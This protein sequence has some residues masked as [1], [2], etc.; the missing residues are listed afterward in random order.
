MISL[1]M[2]S[3][4]FCTSTKIAVN[5]AWYSDLD[6]NSPYY[7]KHLYCGIV[8]RGATY[9]DE[10]DNISDARGFL[11]GIEEIIR[12]SKST[13]TASEAV[14]TTIEIESIKN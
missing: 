9:L 13:T 1:L 4:F 2:I 7:L 3:S 6:N 11:E 14:F 5:V 12:K 8:S 10:T